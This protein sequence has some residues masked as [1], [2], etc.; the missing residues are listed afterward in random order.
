MSAGLALTPPEPAP[1][2][3]PAPVGNVTIEQASRDVAI[4]AAHLPALDA[5]VSTYVEQ[6][7]A[8]D[9]DDAT[10][11]RRADDVRT[12]GDEDMRAS[13]SASNRLLTKSMKEMDRAGGK[14]ELPRTLLALRKQV[15]DLDPKQATKTRK[16]LGIIPF[17]DALSDYFRK[18]ES[19][20][21][22]LDTIIAALLDGKDELI[23][24]NVDLEVE[25]RN[26]W[27][28]MAKLREYA[29]VAE[30]MDAALVERLAQLRATDPAKAKKLEEEVLFYVRQKHQ[31]LLTQLAVS[32]QGVLAIDLLKRNNVELV[33]GVDRA[34][35]T[36]ISALRTAVL[37][38]QALS[39]QKLVLGQVTALNE[40]TEDM[41]VSTS[42]MLKTQSAEIQKQ[43]AS[44]TI[45]LAKLEA[46]FSNVYQAMDAVDVFKQEALVSMQATVSG[47]RDQVDKSQSYLD[48]VAPADTETSSAISLPQ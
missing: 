7:V 22:Q 23:R 1:L 12:M 47:L 31:D 39:T 13:S 35:T 4:D 24:D 18:Y 21:K 10:F 33:K 38:S 36:T 40:T 8:L 44:A 43:A 20:Q 25:K 17:G 41:I 3:A 26:L 45:D 2:V 42:E 19:S 9:V 16:F 30:R 15:E 32:V 34:T 48:R 27:D 11:A 6:I 14:A 37:V 5:L 28:A 46:A 29:Y